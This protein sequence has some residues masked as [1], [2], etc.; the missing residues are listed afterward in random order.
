MSKII[1]SLILYHRSRSKHYLLR[2][3]VL[4]RIRTGVN[5]M[6]DSLI[7]RK[8]SGRNSYLEGRQD[9]TKG[10]GKGWDLF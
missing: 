9:L 3:E 7:E 4:Y 5:D 6:E 2:D 1:I 10:R 8:G